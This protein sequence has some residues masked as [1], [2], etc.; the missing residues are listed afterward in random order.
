MVY[1]TGDTH[2]E[3]ERFRRGKLRWLGKRD[4]VIVLGDFGFV[5]D[6]SREERKKLDWLRRRPYTLL[7]L[8]GTHENYDLLGQYPTVEMFGGKVQDLGG[9]IY[10]VC[11]G[12]ILELEGKSYFCFG[13]GESPDREEREYGVNWWPQEMPS[14]EEYAFCEENLGA[15]NW[16]VDYV[17]THDAPSRFLDFTVLAS[18]ENNRLHLFLDK[19]LLKMQYE[20]W[21]FGCYHKD[22]QLST[23]SRCLFC[24]VVCMGERHAA[25]HRKK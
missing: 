4:V 6:G 2:G 10:H 20:K 5:W 19:L 16:Q 1:L 23:K 9:N 14:D 21:F 17:L 11:R 13:G 12:S 18:G 15:R 3:L 25:W 24:D 22:V 8:D 7:F